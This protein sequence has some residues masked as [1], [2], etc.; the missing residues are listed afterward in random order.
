MENLFI[1]ASRQKLTFNYRGTITTDDLWD[2]SLND[3]DKIYS[4][5][6]KNYEES[7]TKGLL[8]RVTI[9]STDTLKLAI[10]KHIFEV[11]QKELDVAKNA[12]AKKERQQYLLS[13]INQKQDDEL[14][15]KSIEELKAL[16][17]DET[18][19]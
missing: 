9:D 16:L 3:L 13:I 18:T 12:A 7:K 8:D 2:L 19:A 6:N 10:V 1:K 17:E 4:N 15:G 11:K 5:I 14:K